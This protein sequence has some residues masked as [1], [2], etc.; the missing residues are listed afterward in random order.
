MA[1][2]NPA[3]PAT[4]ADRQDLKYATETWSPVALNPK[5][6]STSR[7]DEVARL[8]EPIKT[9]GSV[10]DF[11]CGSGALCVA[12]CEQ[13]GFQSAVGVE[14]SP[15][16]VQ[17]GSAAIAERYPQLLDRVKLQLLSPTESRLPF[18]DASFD[19]V[20]SVVVLEV[21]PD[22]FRTMDEFFRIC[23]P[24]GYLVMTVANVAS[25]KHI[26]ALV[27]GLVP[28]TY[29]TSRDM[30]R[31]RE[32]GWDDGCLRYFSKAQLGDLLRH[33]GFTPEAWSGSGRWSGVR[34]RFPM[35]CGDLC[36]RA[37]RN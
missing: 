14:V 35:L 13:L 1:D 21:V 9:R 7:W 3:S 24:G 8:I 26:L 31:W 18:P 27:R 15:K 25:L 32:Q 17:L 36:V 2:P 28:V 6:F 11:G 19:V 23:R 37:K 29:S 33:V 5:R 30:R 10:L 20:T 34:R 4:I 22:I 12:F 16:R